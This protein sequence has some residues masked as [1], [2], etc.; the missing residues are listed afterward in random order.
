MT[1]LPR[2]VR[3]ALAAAL[4]LLLV[5]FTAGPAGA[6]AWSHRDAR[7]DVTRV[8]LDVRTGKETYSPAAGE[9]GTDI[10]RLA[11]RHLA[12]RVV[13][14]VAVRDLAADEPTS[15]VARLVTP[16]GAYLLMTGRAPGSF[17]QI[18][19][20]M[21]GRHELTCSGLGSDFDAAADVVR[22]EVPRSCLEAPAWVRAGAGLTND[23]S[24]L[25][26]FAAHGTTSRDVPETL[27]MTFDD[28]LRA[29]GRSPGL[30][31]GPKVRVG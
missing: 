3:R 18:L 19:M 30:A 26:G 22:L 16:H 5:P 11:V 31:L 17:V 7:G 1:R 2:R 14:T 24:F 28:A 15:V 23:D 20:P 8:E 25:L 21:R 27:T 12:R 6:A 13:L 4:P 10:T 29:G 9:A